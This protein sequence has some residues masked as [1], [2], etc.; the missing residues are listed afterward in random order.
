MSDCNILWPKHVQWGLIILPPPLKILPIGAKEAETDSTA[1]E[2]RDS[3]MV[4]GPE[5]KCI[6][7]EPESWIA[8]KY[9]LML[10]V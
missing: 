2:L 9:L 7:R 5:G 1:A 3:V 10:S 6:V 4:F 8:W